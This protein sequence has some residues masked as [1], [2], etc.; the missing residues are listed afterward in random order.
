[1]V[2]RWEESNQGTL[3]ES[4]NA[5]QG[6]ENRGKG[7]SI[8]WLHDHPVWRH[9]LK[10]LLVERLVGPG[11]H[12]QRPVGIDAFGDPEPSLG[13]ECF[14]SQQRGELLWPIIASNRSRQRS[15]PNSV[16]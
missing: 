16:A 10:F 15:Q 4:N 2:I 6:P 1:M 14:T 7:A 11:Y 8:A 5:Q 9:I 3:V 13:E 12:E